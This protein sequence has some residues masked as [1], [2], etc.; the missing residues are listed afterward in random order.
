MNVNTRVQKVVYQITGN[1]MVNKP[2][3]FFVYS[4]VN[5]SGPAAVFQ[6]VHKYI[7]AGLLLPE[8]FFPYSGI[9]AVPEVNNDL[10]LGGVSLGIVPGAAVI[11]GQHPEKVNLVLQ[12]PDWLQVFPLVPVNLLNHIFI[13]IFFAA[14]ILVHAALGDPRLLYYFR[15]GSLFVGMADK[16]FHGMPE[17]MFLF[18]LWQI[19]KSWLGQR[20]TSNVTAQSHFVKKDFTTSCQN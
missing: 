19:K 9:L 8:N 20:N 1:G 6:Q 2:G 7:N 17:N 3:R 16:F 5:Y 14:K 4:R 13:Q 12:I 18:I 10:V 15:E 11:H